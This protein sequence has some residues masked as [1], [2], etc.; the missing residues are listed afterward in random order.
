MTDLSVLQLASSEEAF[1]TQQVDALEER[2]VDCTT[3]V[4]RG[5]A[6]EGD[7]RG[8]SAYAETYGDVLA[9]AS[10]SYDLVHANYGLVGPLAL[11]QPVRPVVLT[12]WGSEVMGYSNR[13]D[14]VTR[15]AARHSDAVIAPNEAVSR[16]LDCD[17]EVVPFGVDLELFRPIDRTQARKRLGWDQSKRFVLFPYD[18]DRD[19]KDF[20]RAQRVVSE[21]VVNAEIKA[22]HGREYEEMPYLMNACDVLLVTSERESGPM[23]VREAAACNV[24]VVSTDV[25]FAAETLA[26]VENSHVADTDDELADALDATLRSAGRSNGR[27]RVRAH[28]AERMATDLHSIYS[29]LLATDGARLSSE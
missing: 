22:I 13:L 19:V 25:G 8:I 5:D 14:R 21:A 12:L 3:L 11:A 17:H 29:A 10:G 9:E 18:T 7:P 16:R 27:E 4:V 26:D 2:G 20:E 23:V 15:F 1:F 24:P 28:T 6:A